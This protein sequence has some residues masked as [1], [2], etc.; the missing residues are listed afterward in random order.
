MVAN[1][2]S[3]WSGQEYQGLGVNIFVQYA[4]MPVES[5]WIDLK[6]IRHAGSSY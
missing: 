5:W 6:S 2:S 1:H 3:G 4:G